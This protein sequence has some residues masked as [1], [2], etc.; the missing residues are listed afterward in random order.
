MLTPPLSAHRIKIPVKSIVQNEEE[1]GG[2]EYYSD[3]VRDFIIKIEHDVMRD[4]SYKT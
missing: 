1:S 3:E 2:D 4:L